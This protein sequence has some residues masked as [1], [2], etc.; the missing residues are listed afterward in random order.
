MTGEHFW[1]SRKMY[2]IKPIS[3]HHRWF[4]DKQIAESWSGP[5]VV[6]KGVLHDTRTQQGFVAAENEEILGYVLYNLMDGECEI[7]VLESLRENRGVGAALIGA[8]ISVAKD[9]DCHCVWLVTTNDNIHAIRFYQ[10][11]GFALQAVYINSMDQARKLKP[12]IPLTGDE[13]IPI[14]HEF[15]F[16]LIL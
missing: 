6:S 12:Q 4:V 15:E 13:G 9:R 14:R 2:N 10:R 3:S 11:F 1:Q 7:T 8:V 5:F 16:G